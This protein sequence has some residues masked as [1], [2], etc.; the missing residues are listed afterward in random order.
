MAREMLKLRKGDS[1]IMVKSDGSIEMAGVQD[2]ELVDEKGNMSPIILFAAAWTRRDNN[3]MNVLI[4]NFKQAVREGFFG[5][6][7]QDDF[8]KME[9]ANEVAKQKQDRSEMSA[10]EANQSAPMT[11]AESV[12]ILNEHGVTNSASKEEINKVI[13]EASKQAPQVVTGADGKQYE[14]TMTPEEKAKL[15]REEAR[16]EHIVK[17]GQDPRVKRQQDALKAGA[18][19]MTTKPYDRHREPDL[20][21]EQ[22]MKY[23]KAS[24]SEQAEMKKAQDEKNKIIG[25]ATIEE[26]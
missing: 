4:E 7:A 8:K 10:Q 20:P 25:N 5:K 2:K 19:K 26:N 16:L 3:V 24:P 13:G 1:A 23:Q 18:T 9:V 14:V 22:T 11:A 15:D 6:D 17:Q 21:V 12:K